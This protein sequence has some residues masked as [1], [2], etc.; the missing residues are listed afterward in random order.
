MRDIKVDGREAPIR[1]A[2]VRE[3]IPA[4]ESANAPS[5]SRLC[6]ACD[7]RAFGQIASL[8]C[9]ASP[10]QTTHGVFQFGGGVDLRL[11]ERISIRGEVRDFVTGSGL[12]GSNGPH[13]L[14]PLMGLA[15]HF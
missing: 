2:T 13:H 5:R 14:V 7:W 10:Y 15:M 3:R 11:T 4:T 8:L 1:A 12:S 6:L 9:R